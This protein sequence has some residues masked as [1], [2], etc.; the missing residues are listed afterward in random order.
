MPN[1]GAESLTSVSFLWVNG[2]GTLPPRVTVWSVSGRCGRA[3]DPGRGRGED[4]VRSLE[5]GQRLADFAGDLRTDLLHPI[6][7]EPQDLARRPQREGEFD[8]VVEV[9]A[10]PDRD[11]ATAQGYR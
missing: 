5:L 3:D 4:P 9:V 2:A 7:P 6:A 11:V 1:S 10:D 8:G